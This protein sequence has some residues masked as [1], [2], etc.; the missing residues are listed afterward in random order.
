M[1]Q[2]LIVF[3]RLWRRC[4]GQNRESWSSP[5]TLRTEQSTWRRMVLLVLLLRNRPTPA[6]CFVADTIRSICSVRA[7]GGITAGSPTCKTNRLRRQARLRRNS[8]V[9]LAAVGFFDTAVVMGV[10]YVTTQTDICSTLRYSAATAT[11]K[12][13][14]RLRF[15]GRPAL[16][17]ADRQPLVQLNQPPPRYTRSSPV[18]GPP[19]SFVGDFA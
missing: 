8:R 11:R 10:L 18:A 12:P 4:S 6:G 1:S 17:L 19:G 14:V 5:L 13:R 7:S 3:G 9:V 16:R 2:T 15:S